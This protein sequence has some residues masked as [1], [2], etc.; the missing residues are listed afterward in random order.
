V[1]GRIETATGLVVA[2]PVSGL[3]NGYRM[4][5]LVSHSGK[6]YASAFRVQSLNPVNPPPTAILELH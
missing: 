1:A 5:S 6:R 4:W 3:G 2:V